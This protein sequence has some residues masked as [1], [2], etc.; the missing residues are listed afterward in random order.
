[1]LLPFQGAR[2]LANYIPRAPLR[3]PWAGRL[4]GLQPVL[5]PLRGV[6]VV[7]DFSEA[8]PTEIYA[9]PYHPDMKG[10]GHNLSRH[11]KRQKA[12]GRKQEARPSCF[13][14]HGMRPFFRP[15]IR[16][17]PQMP[18][19]NVQQLRIGLP[20]LFPQIRS[21][22]SV[23]LAAILF[24][25]AL[26]TFGDFDAF[27]G[28]QGYNCLT[29]DIVALDRGLDIFLLHNFSFYFH[30]TFVRVAPAPFAPSRRET[31]GKL[32]IIGPYLY[33]NYIILVV[34]SS[35]RKPHPAGI[36]HQAYLRIIL[37]LTMFRPFCILFMRWPDMLYITPLPCLASVSDI[38]SMPVSVSPSK[39]RAAYLAAAA[40]KVR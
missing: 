31:G 40:G 34:P 24:E 4:L 7:A 20:S 8:L 12:W 9:A 27:L 28:R 37:P 14:P 3:L 29:T 2:P 30:V 15:G 1:M 25:T 33:N 38:P 18:H 26:V 5:L 21:R 23:V 35:G 19:I 6:A 36:A 17:R 32:R 11:G 13:R 22:G 10:Q 16:V 39:N